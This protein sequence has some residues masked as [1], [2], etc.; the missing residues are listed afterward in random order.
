MRCGVGV[1]LLPNLSA[2][3]YE[4]ISLTK[5][6]YALCSFEISFSLLRY[7]LHRIKCAFKKAFSYSFR[8]ISQG[9]RCTSPYTHTPRPRTEE[10]S[11][12]CRC[13]GRL[14]LRPGRSCPPD[15]LSQAPPDLKRRSQPAGGDGVSVRTLL[16]P[17][18]DTSEAGPE[19]P[20]DK[21]WRPRGCYL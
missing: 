12:A 8:I 9:R 21:N 5:Q 13:S 6:N 14:G 7:D 20:K 18:D 3:T 17:P 10:V 1:R 19:V 2:C 11:P 4:H 15:L 16:P